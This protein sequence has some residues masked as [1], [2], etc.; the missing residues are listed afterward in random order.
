M[1]RRTPRYDGQNQTTIA[2]DSSEESGIGYDAVSVLATGEKKNRTTGDRVSFAK[3]AEFQAAKTE[4]T[5]LGHYP[6]YTEMAEQLG[7][8][9][10][11]V[12]TEFWNK[13]TPAEQWTA[14]QKFLD[15]MIS[16]G[17]DRHSGYAVGQRSGPEASSTASCSICKARASNR[18]PTAQG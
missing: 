12:P 8:R 1:F 5:V 18:V 10:F 3:F 11:N 7:A 17:D 6:A 2:Y 9:R 13:M 14:N 4:A 16:R 15:R